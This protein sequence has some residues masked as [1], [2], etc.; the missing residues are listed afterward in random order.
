MQAL[1]LHIEYK[2]GVQLVAVF[3]DANVI[4]QLN[5]FLPLD[6][7]KLRERRRVI[8]V[9]RE[10]LQLVQIGDPAAAD[11]LGD[12]RRKLLI[13]QSQ[14]A[15]LSDAVRFILEALGIHPVPLGQHRAFQQLAVNFRHAVRRVGGIHRKPRHMKLAAADDL[16]GS[17]VLL[18]HI[19]CL[20]FAAQ[21]VLQHD[22]IGVHLRRDGKE[23]RNVPFFQCFGH[24]GMVRIRKGVAHNRECLLKRKL[25]LLH[26]K[27]QKLRNRDNRV[28]IVELNRV[29]AGKTGKIL[30]MAVEK[31]FHQALQRRA[32]EEILLLEPQPLPG[33]SIVVRVEHRCD[34]FSAHPLLNRFIIFLQVELLKIERRK[35]LCLPQAQP[36]DG[37]P[38]PTDHRHIVGHSAH[39][40]IGKRNDNGFVFPPDSPRVADLLPIVG[41][42]FLKSFLKILMEQPVFVADAKPVQRN[43]VRGCR[44]QKTSG[45][46]AK[47]AVAK[48][49]VFNAFKHTGVKA[50]AAQVCAAALQQPQVQQIAVDQPAE[51][52]FRREIAGLLPGILRKRKR[53]HR[54][55]GYCVIQLLH[56]CFP[57]RYTVVVFQVLINLLFKLIHALFLL[58]IANSLYSKFH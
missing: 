15:A 36:V 24:D 51:K 26:Q 12:K 43:I 4:A 57:C 22:Y 7:A 1:D 52:K 23:Q 41:D 47:P 30:V 28:G 16:Q 39:G 21:A 48:G 5:F 10:L 34:F 33:G 18:R 35:R 58:R 25:M 40:L 37:V 50:V 31:L 53:P 20:D 17:F 6:R 13:A 38:A 14:P 46:P 44:I 19:S 42:F 45:K 54:R 11:A 49:I 55:F 2:I 27:A 56:R 32:A 9:R 29:V 8:Q 3:M